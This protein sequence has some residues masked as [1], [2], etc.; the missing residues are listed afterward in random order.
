MSRPR[1]DPARA[2]RLAL[3]VGG[4][5]AW[6]SFLTASA[7]TMVCFAFLDP[8]ALADEATPWWWGPRLHVYALGFFFFWAIGFVAAGLAWYLAQGRGMGRR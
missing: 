1:V 7:A 4:V 2:R 3:R 5:I 6:S 8:N